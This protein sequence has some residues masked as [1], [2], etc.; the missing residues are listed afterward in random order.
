L[1]F[2]YSKLRG[3]IREKFGVQAGFA[4]AMGK[5]CATI[6]GKLNNDVD[7]TQS[8]I[9]KAVNVLGLKGDDIPTYFFTP[10]V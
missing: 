10:L 1:T 5:S 2:D 3:K 9:I 7:F 4:E 6:S 8:E